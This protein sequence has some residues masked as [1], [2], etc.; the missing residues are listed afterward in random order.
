ML[1]AF[2]AKPTANLRNRETE[3]PLSSILGVSGGW[4]KRRDVGYEST[5]FNGCR[6]FAENDCS[7]PKEVAKRRSAVACNG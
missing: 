2:V 1:V 4:S 5:G 6:S 3:L 7:R